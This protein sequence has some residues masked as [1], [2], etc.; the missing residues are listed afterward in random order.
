MYLLRE[1]LAY[2]FMGKQVCKV[3]KNVFYSNER[4]HW[5]QQRVA[6]FRF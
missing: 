1:K 2:S 6:D 3:I 4:L 5:V